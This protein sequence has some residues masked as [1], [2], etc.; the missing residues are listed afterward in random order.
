MMDDQ[1]RQQKCAARRRSQGTE[2]FVILG[3]AWPDDFGPQ[4]ALWM[5]LGATEKKCTKPQSVGGSAAKYI[6]EPLGRYF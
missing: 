6:A 3:A 5:Q 2:P 1:E 4:R